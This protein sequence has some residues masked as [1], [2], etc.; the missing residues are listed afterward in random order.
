METGLWEERQTR[1]APPHRGLEPSPCRK[2]VDC[3]PT[4]AGGSSEWPVS[5]AAAAGGQ[6]E[7]G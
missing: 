6:T 7:P 1:V 5:P 2:A 3:P 4:P